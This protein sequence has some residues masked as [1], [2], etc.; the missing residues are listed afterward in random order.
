MIWR[1]PVYP[2]RSLRSWLDP[3]SEFPAGIVE[4]AA[5]IG[6][7]KINE[8]VIKF[9]GGLVRIKEDGEEN[10]RVAKIL[11]RLVAHAD[12]AIYLNALRVR[13][14]IM[15]REEHP[16]TGLPILPTV[17]Q[18]D[19]VVFAGLVEIHQDRDLRMLDEMI[20]DRATQPTRITILILPRENPP[21]F[22]TAK[23]L[24]GDRRHDLW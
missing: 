8:A 20:S 24:F 14:M 11:T 13:T 16:A 1:K 7:Q 3:D 23:S 10:A 18:A 19:V 12:L 5:R 17:K 21:S 4:P 22:P 15:Q 9:M 2:N 6:A